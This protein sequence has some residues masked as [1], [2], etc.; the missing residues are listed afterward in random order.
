MD[1]NLGPESHARRLP[2]TDH[3]RPRPSQQA[4]AA[5]LVVL[6]CRL[7]LDRIERSFDPVDAGGDE[8]IEQIEA[9]SSKVRVCMLPVDPQQQASGLEAIG[10]GGGANITHFHA[11]DG[12]QPLADGQG[13]MWQRMP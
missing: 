5:V 6:T 10:S 2:Q 12:E 8:L 4:T 7:P 11:M 9:A 3:T 13:Y 1:V